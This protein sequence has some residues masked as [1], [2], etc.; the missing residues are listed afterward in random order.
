MIEAAMIWNEPNNKS[1]WD[2]ELDPDWS[3]FADMAIQAARAIRQANPQ[4]KRVLGGISPIDPSF[5]QNVFSRNVGHAIDVV[6]VHGFPLDWN[7]WHLEDW[8]KRIDG[9]RRVW[10]FPR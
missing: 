5:I 9:I 2:P 6:A 10:Y 4:V 7:R 8:P 1:H 3:K